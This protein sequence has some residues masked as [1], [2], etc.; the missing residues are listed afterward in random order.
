LKKGN[1][2][3][4]FNISRKP[5]SEDRFQIISYL[6]SYL[7]AF[8]VNQEKDSPCA[9]GFFSQCAVIEDTNSLLVNIMWAFP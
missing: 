3:A 2:L 4:A 9:A 6:Q 8:R 1:H 7:L 5:I